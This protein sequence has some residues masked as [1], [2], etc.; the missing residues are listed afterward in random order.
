[1]TQT[2]TNMA[3]VFLT[4]EQKSQ[5]LEETIH[6]LDAMDREPLSVYRPLDTQVAFHRSPA[7]E[8]IVRGGKR[9][10][11]TISVA[12]EFAS[13]VTGIPIT[14]TD[15]ET[16]F[17]IKYPTDRPL[18]AWVIGWD[19]KHIG[20]TLYKTLFMPGLLKLIRDKVTGKWVIWNENI[21]DHAER[22]DE[23]K[24]SSPLIPPRLIDP[25][26]WGWE[27]KREKIWTQC[28][29]TNGTM[30]YAFPSTAPQ[31]KQGDAVDIIWIDED[32]RFSEHVKEWQDRLSTNRGY[33][34]WSVW[35]HS[36]NTALLEMHKRAEKQKDLPEEQQKVHET[37]LR[38]SDNP[39]ITPESKDE[40]VDR[41]ST[42]EERRARDYGEFIFDRILMYS[43]NPE[44][45]G[46]PSMIPDDKL[47][48]V[49]INNGRKLPLHWTRYLYLDPGYATAAVLIFA[50][51]PDGE[52]GDVMVCEDEIYLHNASC[53]DVARETATRCGGKFFEQFVIDNRAARQTPMSGGPTIGEQYVAAFR[54]YHLECRQTGNHFL[55]GSDN[56]GARTTKVRSWLQ[57]REN[58]GPKLRFVLDRTVN[59]QDEFTKYKRVVTKEDFTDKPVDANN[60]AMNC[61][62]YAV[63]SDPTFVPGN[64][65]QTVMPPELRAFWDF[66]NQHTA[67]QQ[68]GSKSIN[69]GPPIPSP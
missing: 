58:D 38:M 2:P 46:V 28:G 27:S 42:P 19:Q 17:D 61:M 9:S 34:L 21:P 14:M 52:C 36:T 55:P 20:Q 35:P 54:K 31:P 13:A 56:V 23:V 26:K 18:L 53:N 69:L 45:H 10:G 33:M 51:P 67:G 6:A 12:L 66:Y 29:L 41:M 22:R 5:R 48:K 47:T 65:E 57:V 50:I 62:E 11:K 39:Y 30:L 3:N 43:F 8:R 25:S 7:H 37:Q 1:M 24:P 59:T 49:Y 4:P 40:A 60:H 63:M 44:L 64:A 15:G 68:H 32:I 16:K